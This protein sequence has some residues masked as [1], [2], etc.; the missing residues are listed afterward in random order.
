MI[1]KLTSGMKSWI[2]GGRCREGGW[3]L[4][5]DTGQMTQYIADETHLKEVIA[6]VSMGSVSSSVS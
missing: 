6:R 2:N 1:D 3:N 4:E 5:T